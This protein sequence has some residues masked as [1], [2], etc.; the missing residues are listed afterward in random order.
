MM[1]EGLRI[2]ERGRVCWLIFE[3]AAR[4]NALLPSMLD[5]IATR[6]E[7]AAQDGTRVVV[8]YGEG[9]AFSAGADLRWAAEQGA[10]LYTQLEQLLEKYQRIIRLLVELPIPTVAV[11][12][13]VAYG[14]GCDLALA[15]DLRVASDRA[16]F[17]EG[18]VRIGLIPDGGGTWMLPRL[19][20]LSKALEMTMLGERLSAEE[21]KQLGLLARVVSAECVE[22]EAQEI[23]GRLANGPPLAL[24]QIKR[25]TRAALSKPFDE[26]FRDEGAAQLACLRSRDCIEGMMAFFQKRT[27]VFEGT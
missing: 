14:F 24:A 15:C 17:Q 21:A 22:G 8:L 10:E 13:G 27:P 3:R 23:A 26:A 9:G 4:K 6:L 2:E 5:A 20:G 7:A 1:H 25:L 18:F 19:V 12:D 11:V 16:Y